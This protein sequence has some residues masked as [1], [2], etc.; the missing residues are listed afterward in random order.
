ME[1]LGLR[2]AGTAVVVVVVELILGELPVGEMS[3][4]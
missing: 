3:C 1:S 2:A 4:Q